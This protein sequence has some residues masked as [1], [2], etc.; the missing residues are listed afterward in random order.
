MAAVSAG[1]RKAALKQGNAL[2]P[3]SPGAPPGYP[4]RN[5]SDWE[6]ARN[7]VGRVRDPGRRASLAKLLRKTAPKFGKSKALG[8][9]WA[10]KGSAHANTMEALEMAQM[11]CPSC[12][13]QADDAKFAVS[14]GT[15]DTSDAS[16]PGVLRTPAGNVSSTA[17]G[18]NPG[19]IGVRGGKPAGALSN[20]GQRDITLARRTPVTHAWDVLVSRGQGGRAVVR[21]RQGAVPIGEVLRTE[22]GKWVSVIDGGTQLHPHTHQRA[23]LAELLGTWNASATRPERWPATPAMP[24]ARAPEQTP[25]M[26]QYGVPAATTLATPTGGSSDGPRSTSSS[27]SDNSDGSGP[28]GLS[29]KG[30]AIYKR[31]LA[32]GFPAARAL[33]FARNSQNSTFG[34]KAA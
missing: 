10:A 21:H 22:N 4:I 24:A 2:P 11:R 12:G 25:L 34:K 16:A 6:N 13:Y 19:Q 5:G 1:A 17:A 30:I 28:A 23:A 14:G 7:A 9:S 26:A 18:M 3:P 20:T 15:A 8:K 32:K 27:T 29:P 31:L 33:Q